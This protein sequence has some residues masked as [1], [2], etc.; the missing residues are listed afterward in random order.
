VDGVLRVAI[1][2]FYIWLIG[3]MPDIRRMFAYHGAEHKVI[4]CY[5]HG[6]PLTVRNARR[7]PTLHVRCGTAFMIMTMIVAILVFTLVPVNVLIDALGVH[8]GI[9]RLVLVIISRVILLPLVAGLSYEVTV[10]WAGSRPEN[11]LVRVVLWPGLQLQRLT[12]NEPDD[13]MLQT[14]IAAMQMVL[15]REQLEQARELDSGAAA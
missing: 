14:A 1:F 5:E 13:S 15:A 11:P 10:K 2:I 4:H 8:N 12:T 6:L 9:A 3:R 7:F